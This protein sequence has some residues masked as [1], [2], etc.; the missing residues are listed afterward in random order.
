VVADVLQLG[1]VGYTT[2][3]PS[4]NDFTAQRRGSA[5]SGP[6]TVTVHECRPRCPQDEQ[7]RGLAAA[8]RPEQNPSPNLRQRRVQCGRG[9]CCHARRTQDQLVESI[10]ACE[11]LN[12]VGEIGAMMCRVSTDA[13]WAT[14]TRAEC[15]PWWM[16]HL[17][18]R[19]PAPHSDT[20]RPRRRPAGRG[21]PTLARSSR[22][23]GH[24]PQGDSRGPA[25]A[26]GRRD[27]LAGNASSPATRHNTFVRV[28]R[29]G[30]SW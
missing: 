29:E 10:A 27:P 28:G 15:G 8:R 19:R 5:G 1:E 12:H 24:R 17:G 30:Q 6:S 25:D 7:Q 14:G 4:G 13:G 18:H 11:L 21:Q 23:P 22:E 3:P 20:R 9:R 2:R 16:R 26:R